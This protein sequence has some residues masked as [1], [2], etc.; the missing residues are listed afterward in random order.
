MFFAAAAQQTI[1]SIANFAD[2]AHCLGF[3]Q[4]IDHA[5]TLSVKIDLTST[6]QVTAAVK[7]DRIGLDN[8]CPGIDIA[9]GDCRTGKSVP[10]SGNYVVIG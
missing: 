10:A 8:V 3:A 9:D 1:D 7:R 4:Q 2:P 6:A 5:Q